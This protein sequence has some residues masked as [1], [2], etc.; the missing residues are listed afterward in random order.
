MKQIKVEGIE[1]DVIK[2]NIKNLYISVLPPSGSVRVS[3]PLKM[4][5]EVIKS[6]IMS[7]IPWIIKSQSRFK[8]QAVQAVQIERKYVSGESIYLWGRR[9]ELKVEYVKTACKIDIIDDKL[10]FC[11]REKSTIK[12]RQSALDEWYRTQLKE[13]IPPI[14]EKWQDILGV[15]VLE[16][17]IKK[18]KTRWGTCNINDKRIW[19]NL[20]LAKKPPECLEYVVVHELV[21]LLERNHNKVFKAYMDKFLPDWRNIKDELNSFVSN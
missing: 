2:K 16:F 12:Q 18:M 3:A 19:L 15:K 13:Q 8:N 10:Y 4:N 20:E 7:K 1:I 14:F 11:V 17:R 21:H 5:D 9:Y 6:F